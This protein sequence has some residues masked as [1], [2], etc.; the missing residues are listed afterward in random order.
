[1][2][3]QHSVEQTIYGAKA[4]FRP[5]TTV[6]ELRVSYH[7]ETSPSYEVKDSDIR[8]A[9]MALTAVP[10]ATL[11]E[12]AFL[13]ALGTPAVR[14]VPP[15]TGSL[16]QRAIEEWER[17]LCEKQSSRNPG[18]DAGRKTSP[19]QKRWRRDAHCHRA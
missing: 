9:V 16:A 10:A 3:S 13:S 17:N 5:T 1:M 2:V 7:T 4:R 11:P 15:Q 12:S 18:T 6:G 8:R 19:H 14:T